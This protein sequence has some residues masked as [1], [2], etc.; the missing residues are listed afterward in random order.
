MAGL[1]FSLENVVLK[2]SPE[3]TAASW[4]PKKHLYRDDLNWATR[5]LVVVIVNS[6]F[7][8]LNCNSLDRESPSC[9]VYM[10]RILSPALR[11]V[12]IVQSYVFFFRGLFT[13]PPL[14]FRHQL[15]HWFPW[16]VF[17]TYCAMYAFAFVSYIAGRF[18]PEDGRGNYRSWARRLPFILLSRAKFGFNTAWGI[19]RGLVTLVL[20]LITLGVV[21]VTT[22]ALMAHMETARN[23]A[24]AAL[25]GIQFGASLISALGDSTWLGGKHG[26]QSQ[27]RV[28]GFALAWRVFI[29]IM[30]LLPFTI[31][32]FIF[33]FPV[34]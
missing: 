27:S 18:Q 29:A 32:F 15:R 19:L 2:R 23:T 6:I 26:V 16:L 20:Y 4:Q 33:C 3:P 1:S 11:G 9:L 12:V 10:L 5:S 30:P 24:C 17:F 28:A 14:T 34:M 13:D 7:K 21:L 31:G 22:H 8:L 25:F